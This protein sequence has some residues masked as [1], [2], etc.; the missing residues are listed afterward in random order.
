MTA[1]QS[2]KSQKLKD[3]TLSRI[4]SYARPYKFYILCF[5]LTVV[6]D[7]ILIVATP[8]LLRKLIDEGVI[9]GDGGVVTQLA[10]MVGAI[11]VLDALFKIA[12]RWFSSRVG[13]GLIYDLRSQVFTH[14]QRQSIAFFTR[15]QTGALIS[16]LNSDVIG[17]QQAFTSTLSGLVS[18]VISLVLVAATMAFLS[19]Q[20]TVASL[21]LLPLFIYPTKWVGKKIQAL[22]RESMDFNAKMSSTMTER[23][24]VSGAMLVSLYGHP[25]R[26]SESFRKRTRAT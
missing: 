18:N 17:A 22:T 21:M 2:V 9:P 20:I 16:R 12:E 7:A 25:A 4:A 26:E 15:T 10:L 8:L 11:A 19:W 14:V 3:G 13:E 6:I 24:N 1:D 5:L 23:F